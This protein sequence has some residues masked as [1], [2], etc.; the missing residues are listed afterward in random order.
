LFTSSARRA[1]IF[2]HS[3]YSSGCT[4]I[5]R[6]AD[7]GMDREINSRAKIILYPHTMQGGE[8]NG[9]MEGNR[10]IERE[11]ILKIQKKQIENTA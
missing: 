9:E 7:R 6:D 10:E 8:R 11:K 4:S 5:E 1:E 2:N 3:E